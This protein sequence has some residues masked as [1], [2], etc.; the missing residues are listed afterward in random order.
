MM[1]AK[2]YLMG[3]FVSAL[4]ML[5]NG[6]GG[7]GSSG[8]T[9]NDDATAIDTVENAKIVSDSFVQVLGLESGAYPKSPVANVPSSDI[10]K[11][12]HDIQKDALVNC[13]NGGTMMVVGYASDPNTMEVTYANCNTADIVLDG[14]MKTT[15]STEGLKL[16]YTTDFTTTIASMS[17]TLFYYANSSITVTN[18]T[19]RFSGDI[20]MTAVYDVNMKYNAESIIYKNLTVNT[21]VEQALTSPIVKTC[22]QKGAFYLSKFSNNPVLI[23]EYDTECK[24]AFT[25]RNNSLESGAVQF[26]LGRGKYRSEVV[27]GEI[28]TY[29]IN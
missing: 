22:I 7:G 9:T 13:P 15:V 18:N 11:S 14:T 4:V 26:Y 5:S 17:L 8:E 16:E 28:D 2:K 24:E 6:C 3:A 20:D 27:F 23:D 25:Y 21:T 19:P 10:Q 12:L 29:K 1:T